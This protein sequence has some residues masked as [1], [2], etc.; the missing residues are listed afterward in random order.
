MA[1]IYANI[2]TAA[3]YR[4]QG[5]TTKAAAALKSALDMTL[6]DLLYMPFAENHSLLGSLLND[7]CPAAALN[8]ITALAKK[9]EAGKAAI[10]RKLYPS[11]PFD[12]TEREYEVAKLAT[13]HFSIPQ[14]A[15]E[16]CIS[17]NTAKS[18]LK[19]VYQ[20][21]DVSSRPELDK[22]LENK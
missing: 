21:L 9:H 6:P 2:L 7:N 12:L 5:E 1:S 22:I 14:I 11:L 19:T 15:K 4:A 10:L 13:R 16:L 18:Y 17:P 3:A 20:K 8:E